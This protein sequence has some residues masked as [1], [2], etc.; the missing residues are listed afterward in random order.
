MKKEKLLNPKVKKEKLPLLLK[1]IWSKQFFVAL[2]LSTI[3]VGLCV[4]QTFIVNKINRDIFGAIAI[5]TAIIGLACVLMITISMIKAT[6]KRGN[7]FYG[8][9]K[10]K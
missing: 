4:A 5:L 8:S 9:E 6:I 10:L 3:F 1:F 7:K 2:I